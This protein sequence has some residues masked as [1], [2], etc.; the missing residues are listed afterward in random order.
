V[1]FAASL[2]DLG[3]AGKVYI[4]NGAADALNGGGPQVTSSPTA[5]APE[6]PPS[7]GNCNAAQGRDVS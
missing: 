3:F 5:Q 7:G 1:Q 2:N 6:R 4:G